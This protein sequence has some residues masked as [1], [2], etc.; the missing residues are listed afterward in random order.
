MKSLIATS[1]DSALKF[2]KT[3]KLSYFDDCESRFFPM[4]FKWFFI[5]ALC[6]LHEQ[7]INQFV[8]LMLISMNIASK[9]VSKSTLSL[10]LDGITSLHR[11]KALHH[12]CFCQGDR[13][14][15]PKHMKLRTRKGTIKFSFSYQKY[16][17]KQTQH[18]AGLKRWEKWF[19]FYCIRTWL[20]IV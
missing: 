19:D 4:T 2:P 18:L 10:F 9:P 15:V 12:L 1:V 7:F 14:S 16:I 11:V 17:Y 13:G 8:F 5:S 20:Y 3:I 6:G